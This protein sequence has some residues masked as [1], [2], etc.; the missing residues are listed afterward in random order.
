VFVK[1]LVDFI[2]RA[3]VD[4]PDQVAVSEIAGNQTTVLELKVAK[5]DLGKIIGKQGRN[6]QAIRLILAAAAAKQKKRTI[7]EIL[8]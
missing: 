8:E 5:E 6:A 7:L 3:L 1:D 2:A 4:N